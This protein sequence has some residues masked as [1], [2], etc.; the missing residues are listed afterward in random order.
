M[1]HLFELIQI[2]IE[3]IKSYFKVFFLPQEAGVLGNN[4]QKRT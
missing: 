4:I 2:E 1:R 3:C